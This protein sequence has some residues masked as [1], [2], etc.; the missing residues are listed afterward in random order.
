ML[1]RQAEF[2]CF[3]RIIIVITWLVF[4]VHNNCYDGFST[5][6]EKKS[7]VFAL[8]KKKVWVNKVP[9]FKKAEYFMV[10]QFPVEYKFL[11]SMIIT[12]N[13]HCVILVHVLFL[14]APVQ[15]SKLFVCFSFAPTFLNCL[16]FYYRKSWNCCNLA[17]NFCR[18]I[19]MFLQVVAS[20][21]WGVNPVSSCLAAPPWRGNQSSLSGGRVHWLHSRGR[22]I[23]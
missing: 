16:A 9:R 8:S 23:V 5:F 21:Q 14:R 17:G 4:L 20:P 15:S 7:G 2:I 12:I 11:C 18:L 19:F 22:N 1:T 6:W 13:G 3:M 10:L